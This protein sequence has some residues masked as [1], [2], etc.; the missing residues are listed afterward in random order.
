MTHTLY[1]SLFAAL[2]IGGLLACREE[3]VSSSS[4]EQSPEVSSSE[5]PSSA[6]STSAD[7]PPSTSDSRESSARGER[8]E[9]PSPS[10]LPAPLEAVYFSIF[11]EP[12]ELLEALPRGAWRASLEWS[13]S[14]TLHEGGTELAERREARRAAAPSPP[15]GESTADASATV[16][17][18]VAPFPL[19]AQEGL[20]R[21]LFL[22]CQG[23][24][25]GPRLIAH[26]SFGTRRIAPP[27]E[28]VAPAPTPESVP[29]PKLMP[30]LK[31]TPA[32]ESPA[33]AERRGLVALQER[34]S[35]ETLLRCPLLLSAP[36]RVVE[37]PLT[38]GL[39]PG[40]IVQRPMIGYHSTAQLE[41]APWY[42]LPRRRLSAREE[43]DLLTFLHALQPNTEAGEES[44]TK[45]R[46]L[47]PP[48]TNS[49]EQTVPIPSSE[50]P[51]AE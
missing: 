20:R 1:S 31:P 7:S 35:R 17:S 22:G 51:G 26:G 10:E 50:K 34:P 32:P 6:E 38:P 42:A 48:S 41:E 24:H 40:S 25:Q 44:T 11:I 3:P 12:S 8:P 13:E 36:A 14:V 47:T 4:T 2:I 27:L 39:S 21:F 30:V 37:N 16:F 29:A 9:L 15:P 23:C 33:P 19:A 46:T 45:E 18:P 43:R 5:V 28:K 49:A